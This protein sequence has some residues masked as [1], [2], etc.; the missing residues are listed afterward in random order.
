M[1]LKTSVRAGGINLSNHNETLASQPKKGLRVS[2]NVQAG[3]LG[4]NHN[5]TLT[6]PPKK[7]RKTS[8]SR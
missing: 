5:E 7:V 6:S 4:A 3:K 8:L 2:T 1:K